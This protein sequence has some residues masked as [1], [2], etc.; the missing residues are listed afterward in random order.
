LKQF[1]FGLAIF[2]NTQIA[3]VH[4]Q[5][6]STFFPFLARNQTG[7]GVGEY[8]RARN[9]KKKRIRQKY[10]STG[11]VMGRAVCGRG[12]HSRSCTQPGHCRIEDAEASILPELPLTIIYS[13]LP[14]LRR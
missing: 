1:F 13:L 11:E 7:L 14:H 3:Q 5:I 6:P 8:K 12:A 9:K 10:K 2:I 4:F